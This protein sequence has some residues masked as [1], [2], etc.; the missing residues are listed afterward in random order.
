MRLTNLKSVLVFFLLI[1]SAPLLGQTDLVAAQDG[2]A[3]T[4]DRDS[5]EIVFLDNGVA[6]VVEERSDL[7]V[8]LKGI[9]DDTDATNDVR[10][11]SKSLLLK[12]YA[13]SKVGQYWVEEVKE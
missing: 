10:E 7:K 4:I 12:F 8:Y 9:V 6:T 1:A 3:Y 5:G 13:T 2:K 11:F